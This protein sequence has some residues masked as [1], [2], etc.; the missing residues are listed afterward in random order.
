MMAPAKA[1]GVSAT[2]HSRFGITDCPVDQA[3]TQSL[4]KACQL[5]ADHGQRWARLPCGS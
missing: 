3:N 1:Q 4:L 2:C 5:S